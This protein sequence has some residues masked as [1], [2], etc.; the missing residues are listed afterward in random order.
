MDVRAFEASFI[1][2]QIIARL[3]DKLIYRPDLEHLDR[4][5]NNCS[6][7]GMLWILMSA[8]TGTCPVSVT[9]ATF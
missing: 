2:S 4:M 5:T 8:D 9:G 3:E 6:S 1:R 7:R